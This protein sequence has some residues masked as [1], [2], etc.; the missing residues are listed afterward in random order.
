MAKKRRIKRRRPLLW[1]AIL[2]CLAIALSALSPHLLQLLS[3]GQF[4]FNH[5]AKLQADETYQ[6]EFW[7]ERPNIPDIAPWQAGL[8]QAIDEFRT[9]YPNVEVSLVHLSPQDV[10]QRMNDAL[11][12]GTPPDRSSALISRAVI[13]VSCSYPCIAT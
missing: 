5:R 7:V 2:A 11:N 3:K 9:V 13:W 8:Q 10:D 4:R 12:Q 1:I 6:L